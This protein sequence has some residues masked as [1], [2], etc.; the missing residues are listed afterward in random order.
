LA[1]LEAQSPKSTLKVFEPLP[2]HE[3]FFHDLCQ[4][5]LDL[6][7]GKRFQIQDLVADKEGL[8]NCLLGYAYKCA[9][10][11]QATRD[12]HWLQLG[13]AASTLATQRMDYRDVLL[14]RAELYV[15]AEEAGIDPNPAFAEMASLPEF[16]AYAVVKSRRSDTHR[17]TPL[18][19]KPCTENGDR[20]E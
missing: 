10:E 15:V 4:A 11:L 14:N 18:E 19:P 17:V 12:E 13:V 20:P 9:R 5:C 6:P 1:A 16:G 2:E 8:Q 3:Q 7:G